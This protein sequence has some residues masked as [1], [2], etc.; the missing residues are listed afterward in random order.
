M[1]HLLGFYKPIIGM[2]HLRPLPNTPNYKGEKIEEITDFALKDA[3][4]LIEGGVDALL[5]ENFNDM[6]Y[7]PKPKDPIIIASIT[8]IAKELSK[9][10]VPLGINVLR[11]ACIEAL[12][13]AYVVNGKFIRC[14]AYV[15][16]LVT[17]QGLL[18]PMAYKVIRYR[19]VLGKAIKVFA[20]VHAKHG[21]PLVERPIEEVA[22]EAFDRGMADAVIITGSRTGV[23]PN[24]DI[25]KRVKSIVGNR[26]VIVGS[27]VTPDNIKEILKIA[28]G[29][30]VGTY[31]KK[32]GIIT[33][34]VDLN[35]VKRLVNI[36]KELRKRKE[37]K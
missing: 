9:L 10:G 32:D 19:K 3:E 5:I 26:P 6:P 1:T 16:A 8:S 14:N 25:L 24:I 31:F 11:N 23:P 2:I 12:A 35:R 7:E 34:P 20:D 15:E 28:D 33:N 13:I 36:V 18:Q 30:I 37:T 29:V 22:L 4:T 21:K 17:D 27:G